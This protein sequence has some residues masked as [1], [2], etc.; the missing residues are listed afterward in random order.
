MQ[1]ITLVRGARQLLTLHGPPGPR[2]GPDLG[3]LGIIE[4][5]AVLI[6]DGVIREIGPTRRVENLALARQ[7]HEIDVSGRVAMPG[8]VDSQAH[9]VSGAIRVSGQSRGIEDLSARTLQTGARRALEEAVRHG[10][11]TIEVK[12]G[13]AH[14]RAGEMKLLRIQSRLK[15]SPVGVVSTS[16]VRCEGAQIPASLLPAIKR[17]KLADFVELHCEPGAFSGEQCRQYL[18]SA[19][20]LG[21]GVKVEAGSKSS[22]SAIRI[23]IELEGASVDGLAEA[24]EEEILRLAQSE[25]VA[26]L[27]PGSPFFAATERYPP[28]RALIEA[29]VAVAL[30]TN[31]NAATSPSQSMQVAIALACVKM[32]MTAAEAITAATI[33]AA[34]AVRRASTVGS[35]EIGKSADL[36]ILSVP[37]YREIPY[38]FGVNLVELVMKSGVLLTRRSEVKWPVR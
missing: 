3:N 2:R 13:V 17:R 16:L 4:D 5:G 23:A 38:Y 8:F 25:V 33:N 19:Q 14:T 11:T 36:L 9:L 12:S 24:S 35:L 30:A 21:F 31:Y 27:L 20:M 34:H 7:A 37:D 22:S 29:G 6:A 28:A 32:G 10:T 1:N 18:A 26:T 15:K